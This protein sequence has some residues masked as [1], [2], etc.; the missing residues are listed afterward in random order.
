MSSNTRYSEFGVTCCYCLKDIHRYTHEHLVPKSKGGN[1]T[2]Y[3]L[4]E[5]CASC[6]SL[7]GDRDYA[8]WIPILKLAL[9]ECHNPE[10]RMYYATMIASAKRWMAYIERMGVKLTAGANL[11]PNETVVPV[12]DSYGIVVRHKSGHTFMKRYGSNP[13]VH[14]PKFTNPTIDDF[15]NNPN[16]R[17]HTVTIQQ[18]GPPRHN[19]FGVP[20]TETARQ[21]MKR[22]AD[23]HDFK[24]IAEKQRFYEEWQGWHD[25]PDGPHKQAFLPPNKPWG[26]KKS[27]GYSYIPQSQSVMHPTKKQRA[28]ARAARWTT[29]YAVPKSPVSMNTEG[30]TFAEKQDYYRNFPIPPLQKIFV[31]PP[32]DETKTLYYTYDIE[33]FDDIKKEWK[34]ETRYYRSELQIDDEQLRPIEGRRRN[35]QFMGSTYMGVNDWKKTKIEYN[36]ND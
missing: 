8:D 14:Q 20:Y 34:K 32:T 7:R 9:A 17:S 31:Q 29:Q 22:A 2:W 12:G 21:W 1:N 13:F 36:E 15:E 18:Y 23:K 30:M 33:V 11:N 25:L 19:K 10:H 28:K 35:A 5:C 27:D 4:R 26:V 16:R 6:N 24:S 3:N